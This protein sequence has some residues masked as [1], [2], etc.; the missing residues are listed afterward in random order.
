M[1][2]M[3]ESIMV[4]MKPLEE[5]QSDDEIDIFS[6]NQEFVEKLNFFQYKTLNDIY[7][8][9]EV[10]AQIIAFQEILKYCCE[11]DFTQ[12]NDQTFV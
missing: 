8:N 3:P 11:Y 4:L 7:Q 10:F 12:P 2:F 5:A 9:I 6:I 1:N